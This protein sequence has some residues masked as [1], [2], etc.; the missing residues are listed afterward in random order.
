MIKFRQIKSF[1]YELLILLF[2]LAVGTACLTELKWIEIV[3]HPNFL[4]I[5]TAIVLLIVIGKYLSRIIN[6][7]IRAFFDYVFQRTCVQKGYY[8]KQLPFYASSLLDTRARNGVISKGM[9]YVVEI[10]CAGALHTLLSSKYLPLEEGKEYSFKIAASS[11]IILE[12]EK[13]IQ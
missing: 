10:E 12:V 2:V 13:I 9:Y 8:I 11:L 5:A 7:G 4:F 1:V 6:W 3:I